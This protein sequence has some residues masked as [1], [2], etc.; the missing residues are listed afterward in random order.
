MVRLASTVPGGIAV[1]P[2]SEN[3]GPLATGP[4][5]PLLPAIVTM[6]G[7][8][9]GL[10][11]AAKVTSIQGVPITAA[12]AA[13]LATLPNQSTAPPQAGP[14][15][16]YAP[17]TSA[18]TV[19][20]G[21]LS[22]V[23][24]ATAG[25]I[26]IQL[27]HAPPDGTTNTIVN[28]S[29]TGTALIQSQSPDYIN[30]YGQIVTSAGS[31]TLPVSSSIQL[32]YSSRVNGGGWF[33]MS[34]LVA[35]TPGAVPVNSSAPTVTGSPVQN[36]TLTATPGAWSNAPW[37][38]T[39]Q[40]QTSPNGTSS[41]TNLASATGTTYVVQSTDV[42]NYLRVQVI[43]TNAA[44]AGTVANSAAT[45]V[46]TAP[47]SQPLGPTG[48]TWTQQLNAL[49]TAA[50][51]DTSKWSSGSL[52][53][54]GIGG[55]GQIPAQTWTQQSV[56]NGQGIS[57]YS[58]ASLIYSPGSD[59]FL[60]LRLQ[61][62]SNVPGG[63]WNGN[64]IA[65]GSIN[66]AGLWTL[67]PRNI[68]GRPTQYGTPI[69]GGATNSIFIEF[70]VSMP[71]GVAGDWPVV[72]MTNDG[73]FGNANPFQTYSEEVDFIEYPAAQ[74]RLHQVGEYG[75][76]NISTAG[77][78]LAVINTYGFWISTPSAGGSFMNAYFNGTLISALAPPA[79]DVWAQFAVP[80]YLMI[81]FQTSA[82]VVPGGSRDM[83][84]ER[85]TVWNA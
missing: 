11:D 17:N 16:V 47:A 70:M 10:S 55:V 66:S 7:D 39:Y 44:G 6:L 83:L 25:F 1:P 80:Q 40:W 85:V 9:T 30:D 53:T 12:Q 2:A 21:E 32:R 79:G 15:G 18:E 49:F 73:N 71:A 37:S 38:P 31:I 20:A 19:A 33:V 45:A 78:N 35:A 22:Y 34:A 68:A 27:P 56:Q 24:P 29:T 64:T 84:V 42:G 50:S 14:V 61:P 43:A 65:T 23:A 28:T 8:V 76:V 58:S 62:A 72:W 67:N 81:A 57:F 54:G 74:F 60:H 3:Q 75:P 46:V 13:Y 4:T 77:A 51:L 36:S 52:G 63:A 59:G 48:T 69:P 5:S 82:T 41:W 26:T